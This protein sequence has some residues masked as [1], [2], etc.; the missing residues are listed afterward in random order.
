MAQRILRLVKEVDGAETE[1][2][3]DHVRACDDRCRIGGHRAMHGLC[4]SASRLTL[5][6]PIFVI[7]TTARSS[8][9]GVHGVG[10][11]QR[12]GDPGHPARQ[13]QP[14]RLHRTLQPNL[15]RGRARPIPVR[16][17]GRRP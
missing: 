6:L 1:P 14:E 12:H 10:Q 2:W 16:S 3:S 4:A 9:G 15:P 11:G 8:W 5:A 13:A 17:A 7:P